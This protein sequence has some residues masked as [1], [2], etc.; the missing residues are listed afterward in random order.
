MLV[1]GDK[2]NN[3]FS[4]G[5]SI[6]I[7]TF[8]DRQTALQKKRELKSDFLGTSLKSPNAKTVLGRSSWTIDEEI[9]VRPSSIVHEDAKPIKTGKVTSR[10]N[11]DCLFR[12]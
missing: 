6:C 3:R 12:K 1:P 11:C 7:G 8:P 4:Y 2:G 9:V 10:K 5:N